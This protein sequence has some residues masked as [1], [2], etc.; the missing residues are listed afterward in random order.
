M[1]SI[2][3][4]KPFLTGDEMR[5]IQQ[6][7]LSSSFSGNNYFTTKCTQWLEKTL[8]TP[9][10][11]L[12][13]SCTAALEM[14]ALLLDIKPG[15]EVI[16]PSYTFVSTVNAFVLRGAVPVFVDIE[17]ISLNISITSII[18][19]ITDKTKVIVAVHY[20]GHS[21]NMNELRNICADYEIFLVE[22]AAQAI[23]SKDSE[24]SYLGTIGDLGCLSFH[25]TKNIIS[26]EGG[27][28]LINNPALIERAHVIQEK[29]TNRTQFLNGQIDKYTW[30]D[31][32]SSFYPNDITAAFL[33]AQLQKASYI[34]EQ[35][36]KLWSR[37]HQGLKKLDSS[38]FSLPAMDYSSDSNN[39]HIYYVMINSANSR[40]ALIN[41]LKQ[42]SIMAVFH[43]IPLHSSPAGLKYGRFSCKMNITEDVSARLLRLPLWIGLEPDLVIEALGNFRTAL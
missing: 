7:I 37:Y 20:A 3:F 36:K 40:P 5:Y 18:L 27:A 29:G 23:L 10:A 31:L 14:C 9:K 6:S 22:D 12:T 35:R 21:C 15:D 41:E 11:L 30:R 1:I 16:V 33:Y 25:E 38:E 24:G 13:H 19:S 32:G 4:N 17:P 8:G 28:L 42:Q 26:G 39:A 34:T 2:P 43:Y